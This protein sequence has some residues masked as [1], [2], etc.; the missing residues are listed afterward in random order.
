M[1]K[2]LIS[3]FS[4]L[5]LLTCV[6]CGV[7]YILNDN[8]ITLETPTQSTPPDN[9]DV[10]QNAPTNDDLWTA[11]G[12]YATSFAGG[13]GTEDDPY[14]IATAEELAYLAYLI[15]GSSSSS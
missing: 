7:F 2:Y 1:K 15:N 14:Q 3:I 12:N 5:L 8:L 13:S 6:S 10:T 9:D 11:S 4:V